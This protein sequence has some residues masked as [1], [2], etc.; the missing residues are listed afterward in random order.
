MGGGDG[1]EGRGGVLGSLIQPVGVL[2]TTTF[3][4]LLV[5]IVFALKHCSHCNTNISNYNM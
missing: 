4:L 5:F 2:A 3:T 1:E